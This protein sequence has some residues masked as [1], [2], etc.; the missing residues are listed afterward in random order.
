MHDFDRTQLE[1]EFESEGEFEGEGFEF[2]FGEFGDQM[3]SPFSET[4][5]MEL[6][7]QLLEITD[8]AEL[9]QFLGRLIRRVGRGIGKIIRSPVGRILGR[10]LKGVAR[11]A[12]PVLGGAV[13]GY[14][15]GPM[16]AAVGSRLAT[17][18]GRLFGLELEGLSLEDQ[19]FEVA[20]RF[21]RFAGTAARNVAVAPPNIDPQTTVRRAALDAAKRHVPGL[22]TALSPLAAGGRSGKWI[23]RGRRIILLGV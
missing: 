22:I 10:V 2:D 9:D 19:E 14:F 6:A 21:V 12:L 7:S 13:G 23:R 3:E 15:G 5:E 18:A 20:R 11:R 1:L 4:E 8:E 17:G 16:G